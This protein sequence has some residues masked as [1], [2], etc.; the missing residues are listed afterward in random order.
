[1]N[2][3]FL[4]TFVRLGVFSSMTFLGK[5]NFRKKKKTSKKNKN[6][7]TKIVFLTRNFFSNCVVKWSSIFVSTGKLLSPLLRKL[8]SDWKLFFCTRLFIFKRRKV[9]G[10]EE[11]YKKTQQ[12]FSENFSRVELT[13]TISKLVFV[14]LQ[15]KFFL[16]FN[17]I[18]FH[19]LELDFVTTT[20]HKTAR[21]KMFRNYA[22]LT[23]ELSTKI[24]FFTS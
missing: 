15:K 2:Y 14:D 24:V 4:V 18:V 5:I 16:S 21:R 6:W 13:C 19:R 1:M 22:F 9:N 7:H 17:C 12:Q 8:S 3:F 23:W 11:V 20:F 10:N